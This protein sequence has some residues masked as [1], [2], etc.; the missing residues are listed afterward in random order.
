MKYDVKNKS[1]SK[2]GKKRIEWA[3]KRM[4]VLELIRARFAKEKPL[5]GVTLGAC[6]HV[7]TESAALMLTLKEAGADV[8]LCASNPLSTQ[9]DTAASLVWDYGIKVFAKH[10]EDSK[11]YYSHIRQV[12]MAHPQVTMDD[13]ADVIAFI[14]KNH[15]ADKNIVLP[16][17][18]TEETTTGVIRLKALEREGKLLY[19]IVA[20]NDAH[21][22]HLFDNRYGTGQSTLDGIIR[23]TNRLIAGTTFVVAGY[24][25]CSR[26][27][28]QKA[29][30]MGANVIVT[31]VDAFKALEAV[32]DGFR[33]MP[34]SEAVKPADVIVTATGDINV[35]A[36]P[37]FAL[38]KDGVLLANSGHFNVEI[39]LPALEKLCVA[40]REAK[41]MVMEYTLKNRKKINV[42][43]EGRLVNL[44]CA[45]GHPAEV[46]DL[47][48]ADQ[49]L[50]AEYIVKHKDVLAKKVYKVPDEIDYSVAVLK[51]KAMGIAIDTLT[52]EQTKYLSSW[53]A[54]T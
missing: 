38:M 34:M 13:G 16:W 9:D 40:K 26:G 43:G 27:I 28:A 10:G 24:G 18:S 47:S 22:K 54:G 17:A 21:T 1:L 53:E 29:R 45:E 52:A 42:L 49:S 31:E 41:P 20:V 5:K 35:V 6:L 37:H 30:G 36:K 3:L 25:W 12:V 33:V 51:L 32:M 8:S 50:S 46:M 4:P 14:H 2:A 48:F 23:A 15:A 44:A 39:E 19:P 11:T 7:T